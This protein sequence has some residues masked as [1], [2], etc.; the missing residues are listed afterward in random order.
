[1]HISI[2]ARHS[3]KYIR[4]YRLQIFSKW[5]GS[6]YEFLF[7]FGI[8]VRLEQYIYVDPD[9]CSNAYEDPDP[10]MKGIQISKVSISQKTIQNGLALYGRTEEYILI[11]CR[12]LCSF[13][14]M[15]KYRRMLL[16]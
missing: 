5:F 12:F 11:Y 3:R 16:A 10:G 8:E 6:G 1:M 13:Y 15:F 14:G 4:K 9:P 7:V 2:S